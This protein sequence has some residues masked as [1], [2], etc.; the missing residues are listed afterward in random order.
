MTSPPIGSTLIVTGGARG[1]GAATARVAAARGYKVAINYTQNEEAAERLMREIV[2]TGGQ[3][4]TC[5][6]DVSEELEVVAMFDAIEV[7]FG[8]V[9]GL[10]NNAG[11]DGGRGAIQD[12]SVS[13]VRRLL[14]VNIIG[15]MICCREAA[16]RMSTTR[17]GAGGAIVNVSSMA[18]TI[19]GREGN[20]V[21]AASKAAID[22]FTV[23]LAKELGP[24]GIR[25]NA[26]RP[27]M[28]ATEMNEASMAD[29][30]HATAVAQ[31]IPMG[32]VAKADEIALPIMWLLSPEAS[33]ISGAKLDASGGGFIIR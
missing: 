5:R 33:F 27:G 15:T 11:I 24:Q 26:I 19:G 17:G 2:S 13:D 25:V 28:T 10:I 8:A 23:G 16:R 32:R 9:R 3:A 7:A 1:I 31:S 6:A 4:M 21:Y 12:L 20:A 29:S 18:A 14:N 30:E 22:V